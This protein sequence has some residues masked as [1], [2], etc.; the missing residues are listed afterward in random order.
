MKT[1][2]S[3]RVERW[4]RQSAGQCFC[5]ACIASSI[6]I[7][8]GVVASSTKRLG[9]KAYSSKYHGKCDC[10]SSVKHVTMLNGDAV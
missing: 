5:D 9:A 3:A 1:T 10:C 6:G 7:D 2:V 4:L 8:C